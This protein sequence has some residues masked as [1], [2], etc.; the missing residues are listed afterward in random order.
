MNT[1]RLIWWAVGAVTLIYLGLL[2]TATGL[3]KWIPAGSVAIVYNANSG[4]KRD[5]VLGP[6]RY[7]LSPL[8][9]LITAPTKLIPALYSQ[10]PDMGERMAPDG[11]Q[12]TTKQ[13]STV[14]F[15]VLVLYRVNKADVWK[16]FDNFARQPIEVIQSTRIRRE[17]KNVANIVGKDYFLE[18][19]IG[20]KREA[21]N[22]ELA[23][24]LTEA[25]E[26]L[27]FAVDNAYFVTAYPNEA[28]SQQLMMIATAD[29]NREIAATNAQAAEKQKTIAITLAKARKDASALVAVSTTPTSMELQRLEIEK[30][31]LERWDGS[32]IRIDTT[33]L[34]S[35]VVDPRAVQGGGRR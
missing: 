15:D 1:K 6:G 9:Q 20:A 17:V 2:I 8:D 13:G 27:G 31:R 35:I 26:P 25:L 21:A 33:G 34:T 16:V 7:L 24:R 4:V 29:I 11:I 12:V 10:D 23:V 32:N 28:Q 5:R 22:K 30:Q 19:L 3:W 18:E 14:T